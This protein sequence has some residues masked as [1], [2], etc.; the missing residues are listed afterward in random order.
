[1]ATD[2]V[3]FDQH[4]NEYEKILSFVNDLLRG[5]AQFSRYCNSEIYEYTKKNQSNVLHIKGI[6]N[7]PKE[8]PAALA[9]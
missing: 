3:P 7:N 4:K 6:K 2:N 8:D 5:D 1:M 9:E